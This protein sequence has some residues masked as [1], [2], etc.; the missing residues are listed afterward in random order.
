MKALILD[1]SSLP[2]EE[3]IWAEKTFKKFFLLSF[4][5]TF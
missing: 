3:R 5:Q 4:E 2:E 1:N